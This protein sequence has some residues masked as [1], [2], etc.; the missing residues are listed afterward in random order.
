[1]FESR[2]DYFK[3]ISKF[4]DVPK[5]E[6][7]AIITYLAKTDLFFL[8][9][10]VLG[11]KFYNPII[12]RENYD[13]EEK[14]QHA[15][16]CAEFPFNFCKQVEDDPWKLWLVARG[17]LKSLTLTIAHN[18]QCVLNDPNESIAIMSY[19]LK[20]AKAFLRQIK[21]ELENNTTLKKLFPD[22]L[23][24]KPEKESQKWSEQEGLIVKRS[25]IRKE[26]TFYAFGLVDSQATGFHF[27]IHS[28]DDVV[29]QDSVGTQEM[30]DKT[31][32]AWEMSDNLG[33]MTEKGTRKKYAGTRYHYFDT[34]NHMMKK[35]IPYKV[36]TATDNGELDG[37][38]I[39]LTK[40]LLEQKLRDQG[41]YTFSAQ[42]LLKPVAK[43]DQKF[44][45]EMV[46]YYDELPKTLNY[47]MAVDPA[48]EKSKK[49]DYT[50]ALVFGFSPDRKIYIVNGAHDKLNLR[51][52]YI[53]NRRFNDKYKLKRLGYEKYGMQSDID[54]FRMENEKA[55]YFM[56]LFTMKG[57]MSKE[58]RI[59]RLVALF[60]QGDILFPRHMHYYSTYDKCNVDI[61][62]RL[63]FEMYNFPFGEHD[64]LLDCLS[65]MFDL[66]LKDPAEVPHVEAKPEDKWVAKNVFARV[67]NQQREKRE[68]W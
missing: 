55:S 16:V 30:I 42:N 18:I 58:D 61:I 54:Y 27:D 62:K 45:P 37:N 25:V 6:R 64:D 34:Y 43:E 28:F 17:H 14:Y 53:M 57:S 49:S 46:K 67:R 66:F 32:R 13:T 12:K 50:A 9:W 7:D 51:E 29:V 4:K 56:P 59:L 52:R 26:P 24:H 48:N 65:R 1:M 15:L 10:F 2:H 33:M 38:P 8:C 47:Y 60:E 35:G 5:K 31:N 44:T 41:S 20:T 3:L 36:I 21:Q 11:W 68:E 23:Y 39:F 63:E 22:I 40:E 19:N